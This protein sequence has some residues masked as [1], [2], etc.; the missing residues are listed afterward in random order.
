LRLECTSCKTKAQLSLKRC[1]HFELGYGDS[2]P[3]RK[4]DADKTIV[5]TRRRRVLR[6]SSSCVHSWRTLWHLLPVLGG[7]DVFDSETYCG[8]VQGSKD[9]ILKHPTIEFSECVSHHY[10]RKT[11]FSQRPYRGLRARPNDTSP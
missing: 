6:L 7:R 2:Q 5:V 9:E 3:A 11:R 4:I 1:K 8:L 10:P